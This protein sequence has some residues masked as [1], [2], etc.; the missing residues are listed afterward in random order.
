MTNTHFLRVSVV[1]DPFVIS[2]REREREREV[3]EREREREREST[4]LLSG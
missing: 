3:T 1:R 4:V 2:K